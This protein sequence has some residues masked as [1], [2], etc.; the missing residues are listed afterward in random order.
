MLEPHETPAKLSSWISDYRVQSWQMEILIAGGTVLSLASITG[1]FKDFFFHHYPIAEFGH[2]SI[3][4]LFGVYLVTRVLLIGFIANLM[5]RAVWLAYLGI[6]FSFPEGIKYDRIKHERAKRQLAKQS[7]I[8]QRVTTL[9][10][11]CNLSYSMA[12]LLAILVTS[13]FI[14]LIFI[15]FVFETLG[16]GDF[17]LEPAFAYIVSFLIIF[18]QIGILD[19]VLLRGSRRLGVPNKFSKGILGVM[20]ILTLSF[21]FNREILVIKTNVNRI[22]SAV[23]VIS[24]LGLA[25]IISANQ[26]GE[27]WRYGTLELDFADA[28]E[29][30]KVP[31]APKVAGGEYETN[32][33]ESKVVFQA[34][35]QSE[36]VKDD[37]LKLFL[38]SW[39]IFDKF[40]GHV[41]N[42]YDYPLEEIADQTQEQAKLTR[43]RAM[44]A[45]NSSLNELFKVNIDEVTYTDLQWKNYK[46]PTTKEEGYLT[47]LDIQSLSRGAHLLEVHVA[48]FNMN[49]SIVQ[50]RWE[51]IPFWKD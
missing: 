8:L 42:K 36:L 29:F 3:L 17:V 9:E 49:D 14:S 34:A 35:I 47:Y 18:I 4:V 32:L 5:L 23:V 10:R 50:G 25:T 41:L 45:Y 38:V 6:N 13:A 30:Y 7:N 33:T 48:Y 15:T 21:L 22:I 12:I 26:I 24:T 43:N 1:F 16:A 40:L 20:N 39:N 31:Y 2:Y 44:K 27:Y 51:E 19:R 37:Q 46:H 11:L 28:R